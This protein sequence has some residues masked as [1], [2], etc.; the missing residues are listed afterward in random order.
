MALDVYFKE[1]ILNALRSAAAANGGAMGMIAEW[2]SDP[3]LRNVNAA[4]LAAIYERGFQQAL[5][6]IGL[7]F[8]VIDMPQPPRQIQRSAES[9]QEWSDANVIGFLWRQT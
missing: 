3:E 6:S 7:A 4:K 2:Q 5:G 1:D 8:G 9:Q